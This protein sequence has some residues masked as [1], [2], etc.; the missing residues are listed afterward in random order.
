VKL[1]HWFPTLFLFG[2]FAILPLLLINTM[3]SVLIA[4]LYV[5]YLIGIAFDSFK[6][7]KSMDVALLSIPSAFVQLV[8]YGWGFLKEMGR[9]R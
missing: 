2:W 5:A 4:S 6:K 7:T 3:L 8:G 9:F 1:V